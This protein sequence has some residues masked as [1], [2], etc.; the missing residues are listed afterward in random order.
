[1]T[2]KTSSSPEWSQRA[3]PYLPLAVISHEYSTVHT[4]TSASPMMWYEAMLQARTIR[5]LS[6]QVYVGFPGP[7]ILCPES[8]R[9]DRGR[10]SV[11]VSTVEYILVPLRVP[12]QLIHVSTS[13]CTCRLHRRTRHRINRAVLVVVVVYDGKS[14]LGGR[15]VSLPALIHRSQIYRVR[16]VR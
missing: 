1:M 7:V 12:T 10:E 11:C 9:C 14:P 4:R 16:T 8:L 2:V 13:G 3:F 5:C 15:W 6:P